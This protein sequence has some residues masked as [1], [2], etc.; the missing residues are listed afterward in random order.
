MVEEITS[1]SRCI[2][3]K[4]YIMLLLSYE[5]LRQN[6]TQVYLKIFILMNSLHVSGK[7]FSWFIT[8]ITINETCHFYNAVLEIFM[9]VDIL[10]RYS[11]QKYFHLFENGIVFFAALIENFFLFDA[12]FQ[13]SNYE[14]GFFS[15]INNSQE[16]TRIKSKF[17]L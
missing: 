1:F 14:N 5:I 17:I 13:E 8:I 12:L 3:T 16:M 7:R 11:S 4:E 9:T 10:E 15:K 2:S 6:L